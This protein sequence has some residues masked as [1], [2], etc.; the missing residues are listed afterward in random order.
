LRSF[1]PNPNAMM[2]GM[3]MD[4]CCGRMGIGM[5]R[6]MVL[7]FMLLLAGIFWLFKRLRN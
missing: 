1:P 4:G 3:N 7:G 5:M 2:R 6:G